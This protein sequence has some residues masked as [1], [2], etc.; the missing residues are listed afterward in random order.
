MGPEVSYGETKV[1]PRVQ[2]ITVITPSVPLVAQR[3]PDDGRA[4]Q[5]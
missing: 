2:L 1:Y 4:T 5:H 3:D